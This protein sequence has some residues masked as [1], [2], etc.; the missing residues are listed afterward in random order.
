[1]VS[2]VGTIYSKGSTINHLGG[3]VQNGKRKFVGRVTE[4]RF[5]I[6]NSDKKYDIGSDPLPRL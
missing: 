1:M 3:M 6:P 5:M 4:K 2:D